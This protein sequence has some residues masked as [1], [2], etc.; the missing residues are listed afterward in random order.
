MAPLLSCG[1]ADAL[2]GGVGSTGV[3]L[4]IYLFIY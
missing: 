1:E 3:N 4:F 2:S